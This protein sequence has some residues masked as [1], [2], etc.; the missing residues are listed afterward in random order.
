[1]ELPNI[2]SIDTETTELKPILGDIFAIQIGT[3]VNNY[4]IHCY[5]DNYDPTDVIPY[6]KDKTL[7]GHNACLPKNTE[8]LTT[9]GWKQIESITLQDRIYGYEDGLIKEQTILSLIQEKSE[10]WELSNTGRSFRSTPDHRWLI[11]HRKTGKI[12][13]KETQEIDFLYDQILL[14]GQYSKKEE[15]PLTDEELKLFTWAITDGHIAKSRYKNPSKYLFK[16]IVITQSLKKQKFVDEIRNTILKSELI[17]K[18]IEIKMPGF[19]S[20]KRFIINAK[21]TEKILTKINYIENFNFCEFILKLSNRQLE[22]FID[23][24]NKAEGFT[25][26][27]WGYVISQS[28]KVNPS[29]RDAIALALYLQGY[30]ISVNDKQVFSKKSIIADTRTLKISKEP[31]QDVFCLMTELS[32]FVIRQDECIFLTGNCFDLGFF[33]K[34][35]FYPDKVKDTFIASKIL[36]NGKVEYRHDFGTV[37]ERELGILYDKS[38]QK[39]IAKIKLS[40][41]KAIEYCFNDVD[42]LIELHNF[43][44]AKII[45]E[46]YEETYNLHCEYI[47]ALAYMEQC[48]TPLSVEKWKNKILEDK[49]ILQEKENLVSNYIN[50]HLPQFSQKQLDLFIT[51]PILGLDLTSPKQM[52][53]VFKALNINVLDDEKKESISENVI[54][55]TKHEFVDLWLNYQSAK[56]DVTTFGENILQK[57]INGRIYTSYNPI[58][59]TAR[60]SSRKGDVNTL[61]LPANKR[62]RECIEA[63]EGYQMIV[64]DYDGQETRVGADITGDEAMIDSI[65]N[66]SDLHCAFARVLYPELEELSDEEIISDHKQKRNASKSPRFCFQF[67]GTGYTLALNEGLPVKEGMRIESLFK[68]LHSGIYAYGDK[69]IKEAIE[70]GYIESTMGFKLHLPEYKKFKDLQEKVEKL[71]KQEWT[72]YKEGKEEYQKLEKAKE[73]NEIYNVKNIQAFN[74]YKQN[75]SLVSQFFKLKSQYYRLCLNNPTQ[76]T[77][78]H[79]TKT[80]VSML[81]EYIKQNNHLELV[82]I[83]IVPHDEIVLEVKEELCELYKEKLGQFMRE[84]GDKFISNPL[85][86]MGADAEVGA[87]WYSAKG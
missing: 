26:S 63:K 5:D 9:K 69:K 49:K 33:Y 13:Y 19:N 62:T 59:D 43:L 4:L 57:V 39:N 87:N 1:M 29:K 55:K 75:K 72:F 7:I 50:T 38:E 51:E 53:P 81:F 18:E 42:K 3:G 41:T 31:V 47:K 83:C 78:A 34:Y 56:H 37:F 32:N 14:N 65:V 44:E 76:T 36:Y 71:S 28:K 24:F 6:L 15:F 21:S 79:Q 25:N 74:F 16:Q 22:I 40:T 8:V 70:L 48:G 58:L 61:N 82:K 11:K 64:C 45:Q 10:I 73:K 54:K 85:I 35:G 17:F 77:A 80:A 23:I 27:K 67:G 68:E 30:S 12:T 46:G 20:C 60:I 84:A 2:I 66:G 52:I 86:K